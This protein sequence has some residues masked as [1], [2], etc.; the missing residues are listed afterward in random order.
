[1]A[2]TG[3]VFSAANASRKPVESLSQLIT[4]DINKLQ[5][6]K[7][8]LLGKKEAKNFPDYAPSS[9]HFQQSTSVRPERE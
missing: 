2:A 4:S 6:R 5:R 9:A 7:K 1:V 8:H 3:N